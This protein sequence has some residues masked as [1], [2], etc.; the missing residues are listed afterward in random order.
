MWPQGGRE[1][2]S[3]SSLTIHEP[4]LH[5]NVLQAKCACS[6]RSRSSVS[7]CFLFVASWCNMIPYIS[8]FFYAGITA[9]RLASYDRPIRSPPPKLRPEQVE[10][11]TRDL[12]AYKRTLAAV[13]SG[14]DLSAAVDGVLGYDAGECKG[15]YKPSL[16]YLPSIESSHFIGIST[17]SASTGCY[18]QRGTWLHLLGMS[19]ILLAA[20]CTVALII[21]I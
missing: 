15:G 11:L 10:G 19:C 8:L 4:K 2:A 9:A 13:H 6:Q 20:Q 3:G 17:S 1:Q 12:V 14:A 18:V 7:N 16:W 21:D 5:I